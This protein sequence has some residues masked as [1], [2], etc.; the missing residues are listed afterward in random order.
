M[1]TVINKTV[2]NAKPFYAMGKAVKHAMLSFM[3]SMAEAQATAIK[4]ATAAGIA[5]AKK[6]KPDAYK[7]REPSC[8]L[9]QVNPIMQ[10]F[11]QGT[12]V[13][14]INRDIRMDKFTISRITCDPNT[15]R[16]P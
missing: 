8:T 3:S 15:A 6:N 5:H 13:N 9:E 11:D 7:G 12:G 1:K 14:Q 4:E 2:F 16:K 10:L